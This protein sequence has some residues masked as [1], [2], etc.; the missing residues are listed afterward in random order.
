[1]SRAGRGAVLEGP[2]AS[3][4]HKLDVAVKTS[5]GA[6]V[7]IG[8]ALVALGFFC[9]AA[10]MTLET[11]VGAVLAAVIFGGAFLFIALVALLVVFAIR[12]RKPPPPPPPAVTALADPVVLSAALDVGRALA[13]RR[14]LATAA[15]ASA[16][17]L[18]VLLN[19]PPRTRDPPVR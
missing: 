15:V 13:G 2:I 8:A 10:F 16:F 19:R 11:V 4:R 1:M 9:A 6:L 5:V 17:V 18:G 14:G 3:V 12:H 7:A